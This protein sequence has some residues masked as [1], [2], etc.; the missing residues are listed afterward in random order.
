MKAAE[1]KQD[2]GLFGDLGAFLGT[3]GLGTMLVM[4][5]AWSHSS[6]FLL[7]LFLLLLSGTACIFSFIPTSYQKRADAS[8]IFIVAL[9]GLLCS[10]SLT[11]GE[12][13]LYIVSAAMALLYIRNIR[14]DYAAQSSRASFNGV[15]LSSPVG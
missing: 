12:W 6:M 13:H 5:Q 3:W 9:S 1:A 10:I 11:E 14:V 8:H 2:A 15:V 7:V 4:F